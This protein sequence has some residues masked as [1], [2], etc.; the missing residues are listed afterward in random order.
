MQKIASVAQSALMFGGGII[1]QLR[2]DIFLNLWNDY[3]VASKISGWEKYLIDTETALPPPMALQQAMGAGG[4]E[5]PAGKN[6]NNQ[7][8]PAQLPAGIPQELV[9]AIKGLGGGK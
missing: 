9:E 7:N 2:K 5:Q 3:I 6:E 1:M 4:I 8:L